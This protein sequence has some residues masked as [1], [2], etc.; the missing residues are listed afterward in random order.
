MPL[1][2]DT[3]VRAAAVIV[4]VGAVWA[5]VAYFTFG[6]FEWVSLHWSAPGAAFA[7]AGISALL[8]VGMA[9]VAL[10][11]SPAPVLQSAQQPAALAQSSNLISALRDLSQ[12]HPLL[13]IF[14]A[15]VLGAVGAAD[16]SKHR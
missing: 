6:L 12:D 7:T 13:T 1:G 15:A 5:A 4:A 9:M 16:E 10:R 11:H 8:G 3:A 2:R 14:A